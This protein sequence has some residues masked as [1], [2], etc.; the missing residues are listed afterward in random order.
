MCDNRSSSPTC[1]DFVY[2]DRAFNLLYVVQAQ[3]PFAVTKIARFHGLVK[4]SV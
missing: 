3:D 1:L 4:R 2:L